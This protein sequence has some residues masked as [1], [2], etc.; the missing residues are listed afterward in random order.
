MPSNTYCDRAATVPYVFWSKIVGRIPW[1]Q[2]SLSYKVPLHFITLKEAELDEGSKKVGG[3][4]GVRK[5]QVLE[6][7]N[8]L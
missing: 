6:S 5:T 2:P 7:S 3:G 1:L 4:R 8:Y